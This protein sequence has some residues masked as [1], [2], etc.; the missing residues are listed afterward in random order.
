MQQPTLALSREEKEAAVNAVLESQMFARSDQL[1]SFL[2]Y[3]CELEMAGRADDIKEYVIGVEALGRP[4]NYSPGDDSAVRS[5]AY[6]LR[7]K[8]EELYAHEMPDAHIRIE[9]PKG[10]YRPRFVECA[11]AAKSDVA[12]ALAVPAASLPIPDA[13]SS[14]A[15][16][17][18]R[19]LTLAFLAGVLLTGAV[20]WLLGTASN[21]Q[22]DRP[23]VAPILSEAWGPLL[24]PGANVLVCVATPVTL[25]V[26]QFE[27]PSRAGRLL[28]PDTPAA[29]YDYYRVHH[30]LA[31]DGKLYMLPTINSPLWGDAVG[32]LTAVQT[33][34]VAGAT[35]Q[36]LPERVVSIPSMRGK[37]IILFGTPEYSE[38][39]AHLL[40]RGVF[41]IDYNPAAREQAILNREPRAQEREFY[42][43]VRDNRNEVPEVYGL[44]T[45]LPS[46]DTTDNQHRTVIISGITS[47]G[48]QAAAEFYTSPQRLLEFK[49][50]LKAEGHAQFPRAYQIIVKATANATLPLSFAYET[51]RV[52]P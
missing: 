23:N 14:P 8:L 42:T 37:N 48:T 44:I 52:L 41:Y 40:Q 6:A 33:L 16:Y 29:L 36:V 1:K 18:V 2:R 19:N 39:V 32:A 5:R 13:T 22:P 45:V 38:A 15:G 27:T 47:A 51:H 26:R 17:G 3:V 9:I 30:P 43:Y 31:G 12:E 35:F 7:R 28:P 20:V 21:P 46:E 11:L 4:G 50:R 25:F 10:S 24:E 49:E 34:S